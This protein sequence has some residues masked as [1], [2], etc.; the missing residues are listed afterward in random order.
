M[1]SILNLFYHFFL[2]KKKSI[3]ACSI[4]SEVTSPCGTIYF[5]ILVL[6]MAILVLNLYCIA[7]IS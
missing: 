6:L 2:G 1:F 7:G 5:M 4:I 3:M